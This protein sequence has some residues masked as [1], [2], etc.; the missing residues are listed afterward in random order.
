LIRSAIE[1]DPQGDRVIRAG[2]S[3]E[4]DVLRATARDARQVLA[5]IEQRE[6]ERTGI[7]SLKIGYNR[8]F[9]YYIEVSKANAAHVPKTTSAS[10]RGGERYR[11]ELQEHEISSSTHRSVSK[12]SRDS[13]SGGSAGRWRRRYRVSWRQPAP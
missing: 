6:R 13:S 4:L 12:K 10:T 11:P 8:V 9:G 1:D 2:F 5:G 3:N 7:K